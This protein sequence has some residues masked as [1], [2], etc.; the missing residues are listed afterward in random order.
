MEDETN[1]SA[2]EKEVTRLWRAWRTVH[3]MV[4]D[5]VCFVNGSLEEEDIKLLKGRCTIGLRT[6][7]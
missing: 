2:Y 1:A 5:R 4:Q 7:R 6:R 3:E